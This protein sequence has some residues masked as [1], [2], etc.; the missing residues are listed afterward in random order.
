MHVEKYSEEKFC[1]YINNQY[2]TFL[3]WNDKEEIARNVKKLI[4]KLNQIYH[5]SLSGFYKLVIHLNKKI[6]MLL[7]LERLEDFGIDIKTIDLRVVIYLDSDILIEIDDLD[8]IREHCNQVYW[9]QNHF[10][11]DIN[12]FTEK[13]FLMLTE[14]GKFIWSEEA[15]Q[16]KEMGKKIEL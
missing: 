16:I 6:G 10:Y 3:D 14:Y 1:I 8:N 7:E 15:E 11:C 2:F 13:Q 4:L 12:Q 5:L 9:Y